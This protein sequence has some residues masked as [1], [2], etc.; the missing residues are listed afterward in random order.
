MLSTL[1]KHTAISKV[2]SEKTK[3]SIAAQTKKSPKGKDELFMLPSSSEMDSTIS[4]SEEEEEFED[5]SADSTDA[6]QLKQYDLHTID[7]KSPYFQSLSLETRHEILTELKET[8][9]QNS[10]GRLHELPKKSDDF[11]GYQMKRLLKRQQV[12]AALDETAKEMG[13]ASLSLAELETLFNDQGIPTSDNVGQ[14]IA[15]DSNTRFLYIK[16]IKEAMERAK[17]DEEKKREQ[18]ETPKEEIKL[19][20]KAELEEEEELR[21]AIALSLEDEPSTSSV[22]VE[23]QAR[24][25]LYLENFNDEDFQSSDEMDTSDEDFEEVANKQKL[26]S[27]QSYML[28]YSGLTPAEISKIIGQNIRKKSKKNVKVQKILPKTRAKLQ[29]GVCSSTSKFKSFLCNK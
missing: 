29:D 18:S 17:M 20:T 23:N 25:Y 24:E 12:Q 5:E 9:K 16:D 3:A 11:S 6:T 15:S 26:S 13:G 7:T 10:W 2:L 22:N 8:R 19:K 28:E 27:A 21:R 1:L 14:R 4:S